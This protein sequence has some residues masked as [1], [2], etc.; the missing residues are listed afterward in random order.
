MNLV[1]NCEIV[2]IIFLLKYIKCI[3]NKVLY[4]KVI[5]VVKF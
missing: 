1:K 3:D 4:K 5:F 2:F